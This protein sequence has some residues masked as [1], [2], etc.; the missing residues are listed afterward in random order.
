M[1]AMVRKSAVN[2]SCGATAFVQD[3]ARQERNIMH[4][5]AEISGG[6]SLRS[7]SCAQCVPV[8]QTGQWTWGDEESVHFVRSELTKFVQASRT[9]ACPNAQRV[10]TYGDGNS[11]AGRVASYGVLQ[12]WPELIGNAFPEMQGWLLEDM[13]LGLILGAWKRRAQNATACLQFVEYFS[14]MGNL[15]KECLKAGKRGAAMDI[16]YSMDHDVC[17][18]GGLRLALECLCSTEAGA[19]TWFGTQCSSFVPLCLCQSQRRPEN[20]YVGDET[21]E[22]VRKGNH[23]GQVT[24]LLYF[25]GHAMCN[26][27]VIEQPNKST[28]PHLPVV[29]FVLQFTESVSIT[30]FGACFGSRSIKPLQLLSNSKKISC[31]VRQRPDFAALTLAKSDGNGRY[32]G[33]KDALFESEQY[34]REFGEAIVKMMWQS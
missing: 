2:K 22:F 21:R 31:M 11:N 14:G 5:F 3:R 23:L 13:L 7:I 20:N 18:S 19:L 32:T 30:T 12:A 27:C 9:G 1:P 25:L 33:D 26:T 34:T 16:A 6:L 28:L 24:A 4:Q 15:S 29:L 10:A 17:T 8:D